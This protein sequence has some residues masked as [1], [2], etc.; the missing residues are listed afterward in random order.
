MIN[1]NDNLRFSTAINPRIF[2]VILW[3]GVSLTI[4]ILAGCSDS[5]NSSSG[6]SNDNM[7]ISDKEPATELEFQETEVDKTA[8]QD[9]D[10][11]RNIFTTAAGIDPEFG[12]V[13]QR[14]YTGERG[15]PTIVR[16]DDG[17]FE[18]TLPFAD[19]PSRLTTKDDTLDSFTDAASELQGHTYKAWQLVDK[20]EETVLIL[21]SLEG[22]EFLGMD[23]W[24][25]GGYW[26]TV[27]S[28]GEG[29]ITSFDTG[30]FVDGEG[31]D[32]ID[33][34]AEG[35]ASY[36]GLAEGIYS[37]IPAEGAAEV[38]TYEGD[39]TATAMFGVDGYLEGTINLKDELSGT[40][41]ILVRENFNSSSPIQGDISGDIT[42]EYKD[43]T[44]QNVGRWGTRFSYPDNDG[45]PKVVAGTHNGFVEI[46]SAEAIG[47]VGAHAGFIENDN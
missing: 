26:L 35:E 36:K 9:P 14:I 4:F 29:D 17:E 11:L 3:V 24:L 39:L 25:A 10:E 40:K 13:V 32:K 45:M 20:D 7:T 16:T 15:H 30:A 43:K 5:N 22:S 37:I 31:F 38:G 18:L 44:Y 28:D 1:T 21:Y 33:L 27:V 6:A 46:P 12:S 34:P 41:I 42:V 23:N 19:G 2:T 47:F 8:K